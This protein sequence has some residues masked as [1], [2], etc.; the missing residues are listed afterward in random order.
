VLTPEEREELRQLEAAFE[1][2]GGR[3]VDL[4]ERVDYLRR[5]ASECP[6]R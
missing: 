3:G 6:T 2:A 5:K 4:A 1:K